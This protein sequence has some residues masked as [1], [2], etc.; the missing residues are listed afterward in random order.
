VS[1]FHGNFFLF[2]SCEEN[3]SLCQIAT[4]AIK[5]FK[6]IKPQTIPGPSI[7]LAW[8]YFPSLKVSL[9]VVPSRTLLFYSLPKVVCANFATT[10]LNTQ[11]KAWC[12]LLANV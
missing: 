4:Q 7:N 11:K 9:M 1:V 12:S 5:N 10:T 8:V 3:K 6:K 2:S